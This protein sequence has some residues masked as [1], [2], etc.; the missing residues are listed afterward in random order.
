MVHFLFFFLLFFVHFECL[1]SDEELDYK[2]ED[3]GNQL[4][5]ERKSI[6]SSPHTSSPTLISKGLVQRNIAFFERFLQ[7]SQTVKSGSKGSKT[8]I[9]SPF[10]PHKIPSIRD[11]HQQF[12]DERKKI[13]GKEKKIPFSEKYSEKYDVFCNF[14]ALSSDFNR[15]LKAHQENGILLRGT[16]PRAN[17]AFNHMT[18]TAAFYEI[19]FSSIK[20]IIESEEEVSDRDMAPL[21]AKI[22]SFIRIIQAVSEDQ[23]SFHE[24]ALDKIDVLKSKDAI[25]PTYILVNKQDTFARTYN[26]FI[27][28]VYAFFREIFKDNKAFTEVGEAYHQETLRQLRE[29]PK[30]L[31]ILLDSYCRKLLSLQTEI[32][33][34]VF[35]SKASSRTVSELCLSPRLKEMFLFKRYRENKRSKSLNIEKKKSAM[36]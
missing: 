35:K 6:S 16:V 19:N 11:E 14:V 33:P 24:W 32:P 21:N 23:W 34:L 30:L 36:L 20:L 3:Q 29:V 5:R 10:M 1:G 13:D 4:S 22:L 27:E 28:S 8:P 15:E 2:L 12:Q 7:E 18:D 9:A 17:K 25:K 31:E 26:P